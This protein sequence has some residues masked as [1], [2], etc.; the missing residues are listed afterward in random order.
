MLIETH[1]GALFTS[2]TMVLALAPPLS[3]ESSSSSLSSLESVFS[4]ASTE[5]IPSD[6]APTSPL[7]TRAEMASVAALSPPASPTTPE[8]KRGPSEQSE[9]PPA[10]KK[11]KIGIFNLLQETYIAEQIM[12]PVAFAALYEPGGTFKGQPLP[13]EFYEG[14]TRVFNER[15]GTSV[16]T[17]QVRG[18]LANMKWQ[19]INTH[20]VKITAIREGSLPPSSLEEKIRERCHYYYTLEPALIQTLNNRKSIVISGAADGD[21]EESEATAEADEDEGDDNEE[22]ATDSQATVSPATDRQATDRQATDS[23]ATDSQATSGTNEPR[24]LADPAVKTF[25][26]QPPKVQSIATA[27]QTQPDEMDLL[28]MLKDIKDTSKLQCEAEK[29]QTRREQ[30]RFQERARAQQETNRLEQLRIEEATKRDQLRV[31]EIRLR[32]EELTKRER[33]NI[34]DARMRVEETKLREEEATKREEIRADVEK[35]KEQVRLKELEVEHTS[36]LLLLEQL[37][38]KRA[39][40]EKE[41]LAALRFKKNIEAAE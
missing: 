35:V 4:H 14:F 15:F 41:G 32:E 1:N 26:P 7:N 23:P 13:R 19:W 39:I 5:L 12:D 9:P 34:E 38:L 37:R 6:K 33:L 8:R 28:D 25:V 40:V 30:L 11:M 31:E 16:N 21:E 22:Q 36:K 18:K 2:Q 3:R 17:A 20:R 27:S 24:N 10:I 29:E